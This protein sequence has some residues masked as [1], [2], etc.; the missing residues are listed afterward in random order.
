M[1]TVEAVASK[2][3]RPGTVGPIAV[4]AILFLAGSAD[5]IGAAWGYGLFL[6]ATLLLV[7][8]VVFFAIFVLTRM[9]ESD[10]LRRVFGA[11]LWLGAWTYVLAVAALSGHFLY[12]TLQGRMELKWI[13]F[14]PAALAALVVLDWGLYRIL[15]AGNAPTWRRY[16]HV[17]SRD[18]IDSAALKKTLIDEVILHRTLLSVSPFRWVRHQLIFWG[19]GLMFAT[20]I[21]AVFFREAFPAFGL[22]NLWFDQSH[23]VR[24]AFDF[25]YDIT[26]LMVMV[27]CILALIYRARVNGTPDQ[28]FTDTPTA[29]FLLVVVVTG[30]LV[31]GMRLAQGG[32]AAASPIGAIFAAFIPERVAQS[33]LIT[34]VNWL[35]HVLLSCAFIAYVPIKRL[36]HSCATPIGRL[37]NSQKGMLAAKKTHALKGLFQGNRREG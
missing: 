19:F 35:F 29:V 34:E 37:M 31:E 9:F 36:V 27:G 4:A 32:N 15:V 17:V 28:K 11:A 30:F 14:G 2:R 6:I 13:I 12:E 24:L 18:A 3:L 1:A 21:L 22:T 33:G 26:G 16:G 5:V 23:P 7:S 25:T 10:G 20:E 8:G